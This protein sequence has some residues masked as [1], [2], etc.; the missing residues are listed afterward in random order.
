MRD[1]RRAFRYHFVFYMGAHYTRYSTIM[2]K[3]ARIESYC[4]RLFARVGLQVFFDEVD[5]SNNQVGTHTGR[6]LKHKLGVLF[7]LCLNAKT[8]FQQE[9]LFQILH[10][11]YTIIGVISEL[12]FESYVLPGSASRRCGS[13]L[14]MLLPIIC[15]RQCLTR[16]NT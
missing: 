2:R 11:K 15:T 6:P 13:K 12:Y 4:L 14:A 7:D 8:R 3:K 5:T 1:T 10:A 16:Q 9:V